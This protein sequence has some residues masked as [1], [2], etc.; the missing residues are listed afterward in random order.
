MGRT[1]HALGATAVTA[2]ALLLGACAANPPAPADRTPTDRT[3]AGA[4]LSAAQKA[5][6][7]RA[8]ERLVHRC[9]QDQGWTYREQP[10]DAQ[11]EAEGAGRSFP[12]LVDDVAWAKKYGYG[13]AFTPNPGTGPDGKTDAPSRTAQGAPARPSAAWTRALYGTGRQVSVELPGGGRLSTSDRGC[14]ASARK[15]LYGDLERWFP[16][17]R[18]TDN[19]DVFVRQRVRDDRA[20]TDAV[21]AWSRCARTHGHDVGSPGELREELDRR[22]TGRTPAEARALEVATAVVEATCARSSGMARTVREREAYWRPRLR[23]QFREELDDLVRLERAALPE[24]A[25]VLRGA[26][27]TS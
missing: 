17:R 20:F 9:M 12:Y 4:P 11:A 15:T 2:A 3:P 5:T 23:A 24:A 19:I 8:E 7:H 14:L 25:T 26:A 6:L 1:K 18:I 16:A 22:V 10:P 13:D 21:A 27:P